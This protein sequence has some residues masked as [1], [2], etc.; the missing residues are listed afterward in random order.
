MRLVC[1]SVNY[2]TV[3]GFTWIQLKIQSR[4]KV[5]WE[6]F[7]QKINKDAKEKKK[8]TGTEIKNED[9]SARNS[10]S[11]TNTSQN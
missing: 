9:T 3:G 5:Q 7:E 10:G 1:H 8:V 4:L 11:I 2:F 6:T